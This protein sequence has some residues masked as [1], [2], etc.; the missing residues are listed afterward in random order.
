MKIFGKRKSSSKASSASDSTPDGNSADTNANTTIA[1][2][3][4]TPAKQESEED[5]NNV[6]SY[7]SNATES[8]TAAGS[9]S[10]NKKKQRNADTPNGDDID[11]LLAMDPNDLN[12]KQRRLVRRHKERD[13]TSTAEPSA[14]DKDKG[15]GNANSDAAKGADSAKDQHTQSK[16]EN[17]ND[18]NITEILSKLEGMNS[19]DRR[20]YLRQ[21]KHDTGGTIDESVIAAAQE[22]AKKVA[23][24]NEK[25]A[26]ADA[27][28]TRDNKRKIMDSSAA[29][30]GNTLGDSTTT[31]PSS[32]PKKK[33]RKK[34][35]AVDIST[36]TPEERARRGQ[37]R[38]M[39]IE[40]VERRAAGLVDPT[41][42]PLNSERRRANRRKPSKAA[43][44][45]QAKKEALAERGKFNAVGYQMRRG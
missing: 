25:E 30:G 39:Q 44:I 1:T 45:A 12:S 10:K 29:S 11:V 37:Q 22:Q 40:A 16:D 3:T 32:K 7:F 15:E 24:R 28:T 18:P 14:E 34:K 5:L 33:R 13:G 35:A 6:P 26:S 19:K 41:R 36:L 31:T 2:A 21:L 38:Q 20:K 42:H 23:E 9:S 43:L 17:A 27:T 8:L 4:T